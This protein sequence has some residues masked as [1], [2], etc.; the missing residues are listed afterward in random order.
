MNKKEAAEKG[1]YFEKEP[2]PDCKECDGEGL[3]YGVSMGDVN[4]GVWECCCTWN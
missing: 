3:L 2:N 1:Y 4:L